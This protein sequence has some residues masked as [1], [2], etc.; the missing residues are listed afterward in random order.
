[1]IALYFLFG[2]MIIM[3]AILIITGIR[4]KMPWETLQQYGSDI[5]QTRIGNR[6][7][8]FFLGLVI[9]G[10]AVAFAVKFF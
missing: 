3:G 10:F 4:N 6:Y 5:S 9:I 1:M 2:L 8:A 7:F